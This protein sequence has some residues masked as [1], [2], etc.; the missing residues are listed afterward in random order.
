MMSKAHDRTYIAELEL[1]AGVSV[2][3]VHVRKTLETLNKK[4]SS[5]RGCRGCQRYIEVGQKHLFFEVEAGCQLLLNVSLNFISRY[6]SMK[7]LWQ[8]NEL[9]LEYFYHLQEDKEPLFDVCD[10]L[11]GL[12]KVATGTLSTLKVSLSF[13]VYCINR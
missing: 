11:R 3:I 8:Q 2:N 10:T 4:P 13:L 9:R 6:R 5:N 7:G 12:L 1:I